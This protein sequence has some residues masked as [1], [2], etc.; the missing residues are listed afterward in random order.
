MNIDKQNTECNKFPL[1]NETFGS[2]AFKAFSQIQM[3][4]LN[5]KYVVCLFFQVQDKHLDLREFLIKSIVH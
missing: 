4:N 2:D 5:L 3:F 1:S